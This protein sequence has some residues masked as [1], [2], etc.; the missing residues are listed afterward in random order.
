MSKWNKITYAVF[1]YNIEGSSI[2]IVWSALNLYT[3]LYFLTG[4][5][6]AL[7]EPHAL[8]T[9]MVPSLRNSLP[10]TSVPFV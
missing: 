8:A 4:N 10:L 5:N 7:D 9:R 3:N 2:L 1:L 6:R